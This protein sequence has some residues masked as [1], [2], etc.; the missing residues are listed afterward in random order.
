MKLDRQASKGLAGIYENSYMTIQQT[1]SKFERTQYFD[2]EALGDDS[3]EESKADEHQASN[4][5]DTVMMQNKQL[6]AY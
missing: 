5:G 4:F 1:V 3:D 2:A 6:Q